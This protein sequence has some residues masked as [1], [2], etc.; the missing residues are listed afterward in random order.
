MKLHL[1]NTLTGEKEAVFAADGK[2]LRFY[3]CGPTV[4]G[5]AHIGNFRTFV[6]QDVFRRVVEATGLPTCH[7]RNITDV[8]DKTIRES[9]KCGQTL[10][11]FTTHWRTRFE[12]DCD[13]LGLLNPHHAPSAVEHIPGQIALIERLLEKELAYAGSDGSIYFRI[14]AFEGYGKLSGLK[15][16]DNRA[17]ADGRLQA[18]DEYAKED[19]AD[20]ALWKSWKEEDGPNR[21]DSPWGPGRPG[22]HIE[23]S[24]MSMH[25]LGESF[26]LHSG[27][28][29][30]IFPHHE[31]E[32][33]QSEGATGKPFVRH[34]FHVAH[35]RVEGKK[36]SKSLGNLYSLEDIKA[37]GFTPDE[38]RYVLLS[39]HYRQ[40]LNFT[41]DSL[42]AAHQA[43]NRLREFNRR[44]G[45]PVRPELTSDELAFGP[46][47]PVIEALCNDLNTSAA[48]GRL[49]TVVRE[50]Q[51]ALEANRYADE[52]IVACRD[53]FAR[54]LYALGLEEAMVPVEVETPK[55]VKALAERRWEAKQNRDW[56]TADA[57]RAEINSM[58]WDV[59][60]TSDGYALVP[61]NG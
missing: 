12:Q 2:T 14:A 28:V 11:D 24:A 7:V 59:K 45:E 44:L 51:A 9:Q 34:W 15:R 21:W 39:G 61:A 1:H 16:E 30:L 22:W 53:G 50:V 27:G 25:Y 8:D 33:A 48:L 52:E 41:W 10:T 60:D 17:N 55:A 26:D 35:L 5:V 4:Y 13:V 32:I 3:C 19:W 6:M 20:F 54:I 36:M 40:P 56:A 46:F 37:R 38:L 23:C 29:D 43:L 58:G 47:T 42:H 57:L 49:F 18:D 31:N